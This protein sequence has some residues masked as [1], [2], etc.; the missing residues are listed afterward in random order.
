MQVCQPIDCELRAPVLDFSYDAW[1]EGDDCEL[2]RIDG[3]LVDFFEEVWDDFWT[4]FDFD[5]E[6][7]VGRDRLE[8][9]SE[10]WD[11]WMDCSKRVEKRVAND[12]GFAGQFFCVCVMDTHDLLVASQVEVP[13]YGIGSSFPC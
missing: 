7:L 9:F 5:V 8:R 13:L 12:E 6:F 11:L 3:G 10:R 1:V 2:S 4:A